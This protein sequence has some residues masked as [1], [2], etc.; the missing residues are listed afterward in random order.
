MTQRRKLWIVLGCLGALLAM[1]VAA[2]LLIDWSSL[3]PQI[4]AAVSKATGRNVRVDGPLRLHLLPSPRLVADKVVIGGF[5]AAPESLLNAESIGVAVELMPLLRKQIEVRYVVIDAPVVT[6]V[7]YADGSNNWARQDDT[8]ATTTDTALTIQDFRINNGALVYRG[9]DG[10]QT[11]IDKADLKV[12]V[13]SLSGP[14]DIEGT[15]QYKSA[16]LHIRAALDQAAVLDA[17]ITL[18]DE[19]GLIRVKGAMPKDGAPL[20]ASIDLKA[21]ALRR[22]LDALPS[23]EPAEKSNDDLSPAMAGAFALSGQLAESETGYRLNQGRFTLGRS[24]GA[25]TL[26][27]TGGTTSR[28][29]GTASIDSLAVADFQSPDAKDKPTEIPYPLD[30]P[31]D[32]DIDLSLSIANL[33]WEKLRLRNLTIPVRL[34]AGVLDL[35]KLNAALP[36]NSRLSALARIRSVDGFADISA[37]YALTSASLP[38]LLQALAIDPPLAG[39]GSVQASGT[40]RLAGSQLTLGGLKIKALGSTASGSASLNLAN[41]KEAAIVSLAIDQLDMRR[42][43]PAPAKSN[44]AGEPLPPVDFRLAIGRLTTDSQ[45]LAGVNASGRLVDGDLTLTDAG[46]KALAGMTVTAKGTIRKALED[47]RE[48]DLAISF[49][50]GH[51]NGT[52]TV[53]GPLAKLQTNVQAR[54]AGADV[55]ADGWVNAAAEQPQFE[56]DAALAAPE[57][58]RV[59]AALS[60]TP[61]KG[62]VKPLGALKGSAKLRS[63]GATVKLEPLDLR[64]GATGV[65]GTA[66]LDRSASVPRLTAALSAG[67]LDL[68]SFADETSASAALNDPDQRWSREPLPIDGIR[69][70]DGTISLVADQ[71]L[72]AGYDMRGLKLRLGFPGESV[73]LEQ[74]SAQLLD[75]LMSAKGALDTAGPAPK[76][77]ANLTMTG[78]PLETVMRGFAATTPATGTLRFNATLSATGTS[79]YALVNA[80]AGSGQFAAENGII[81]KIDVKAVNDKMK[82]LRTVNDFI[83]FTTTA[84]KGGETRYHSLSTGLA[85]QNGVVRLTNATSD[86][87]GADLTGSGTIDLP[88][89]RMDLAGALKLQD[90]AEAPPIGFT[91]RGPIGQTATAYDLAGIQ[92]FFATRVLAA[93]LR[94]VVDKEGFDPRDLIGGKKPAEASSS[95]GTAATAAP[96]DIGKAAVSGVLKAIAKPKTPTAPAPAPEAP[97]AAPKSAEDDVKDLLKRGIGGL[98]APKKKAQPAPEEPAPAAEPPS[99]PKAEGYSLSPN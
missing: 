41:D 68:R 27:Y 69:A 30:L 62:P 52:A 59:F 23:D 10:A 8:A 1:L 86:M 90:H 87:D 35:P 73:V 85:I 50:G 53:A 92:K 76:M 56:L 57:A 82:S 75:G 19:A 93:G 37:S 95:G 33:S 18:G 49:T 72:Y 96:K 78:V 45:S 46:V 98:L 28:I 81:R 43:K 7:A 77:T 63:A 97:Q 2:P 15:L 44:E 99:E 65:T 48:M 80:L 54:F 38:T 4:V 9:V 66:S 32:M 3:K 58:T 47:K 55:T 6:L 88:D 60:D 71:V 22:F 67:R 79:Q 94:A 64:I 91:V 74:F 11:R 16:P 40:A 24:T 31:K 12:A 61:P 26:D 14:F 39:L 42:I 20:N 83:R 25:L 51:L 34:R 21:P 89:W 84:L 5:G 36:G 17:T 29:A 13:G 70:I